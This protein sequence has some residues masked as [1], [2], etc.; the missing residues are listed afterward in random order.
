MGTQ[1]VYDDR[2]EADEPPNVQAGIE[3]EFGAFPMKRG[4]NYQAIWAALAAPFHPNELKTKPGKGKQVLTF[5]TAR[6]VMNRLDEILGPEN[7]TD[8]YEPFGINGCRCRLTVTMPD[9]KSITKEGVG[10]VTAMNDP[11]DTDK[12]GES[13][14]LKRAAVK[15]GVGRY[16]YQDGVPDF[17]DEAN[18]ERYQAARQAEQ[19]QQPRQQQQANGR[20]NANHNG[21]ANGQ[22]NANSN[23]N[24]DRQRAEEERPEPPGLRLL[25]WLED[26]ARVTRKEGKDISKYAT[27][28]AR[29]SGYP[30]RPAQWSEAQ[31]DAVYGAA[32]KQLRAAGHNV[33]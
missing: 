2:A 17:V 27:E 29:R 7:W 12:T 3:E 23:G 28:W 11:S 14:S 33:D 20:P 30:P 31:A 32:V 8:T 4:G 26:W 16:L 19:Q 24:Q 1:V 9:G 10:G 25:S 18:A 13:D 22:R 5:V 15:L 6:S 21:N